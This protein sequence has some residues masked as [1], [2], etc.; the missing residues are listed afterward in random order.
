MMACGRDA[1]VA[2]VGR[3]GIEVAPGADGW[4]VA[5]WESWILGLPVCWLVVGH[6]GT[7]SVSLDVHSC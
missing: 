1:T 5:G 4:A 3:R 6:D 2:Q 7:G